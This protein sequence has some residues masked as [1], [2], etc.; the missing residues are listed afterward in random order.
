MFSKRG[1]KY[2]HKINNSLLSF[3][4]LQGSS[5]L[6]Y[7]YINPEAIEI[8]KHRKITLI[9]TD[10]GDY[11]RLK[12]RAVKKLLVKRYED[13][14][15]SK[16]YDY[17]LLSGTLG[18]TDDMMGLLLNVQ[19]GCGT[20]T[21]IIVYQHNHLW[22]WILNFLERYNLKSREI[23]HNWLSVSDIKSYLMGAGFETTR[24]YR[25]TIC[26][27][28]PLGLGVFVNSLFTLLPIL[29][30]FKLDQYVVSRSIDKQL[31]DKSLTICITVRNEKENIEPIVKSLPI[32]TRNQ[33]ILF[34]E[35]Y[36]TDGTRLEI[37]RV[38]N[39]YPKK[40][41]RVIG[42]PG[43]GQGDAIRV[44]FKKA[45]GE[46]IILYEGDQTSDPLDI[47]YF[48]NAIL[49]QKFEFIEGSRFVYPLDNDRMP[50]LKRFGN[51][52]FAK[53]F[54]FF[55]GQTTTDVLS[56]IKVITK[57]GYE[58]VYQTWGKLG[59]SDPFGDFELLYGA[60]RHGLKIGEIPMRYYPRVYGKSK[61]SIFVHGPIL[62]K[63]ALFGYWIFRSK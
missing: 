9:L 46:I 24:L 6:V 8:F 30:F 63:M 41:V 10:A 52:V 43:R 32:V 23:V 55:L 44:G 4:T 38:A 13:Y 34:V 1:Y 21:R 54:S 49:T 16:K 28:N 11:S 18:K 5:I 62:I 19:K 22:Q 15:P 37:R 39:K 35:G 60:V 7:G 47:K 2:Y 45:K 14:V 59:V 50:V 42:Q 25:R 17:I 48:Y 26:P 29:D 27:I 33:E 58:K 36:S 3:L 12:L 53:W 51:I 40:N 61:T 20:S 57:S 31:L 56:G